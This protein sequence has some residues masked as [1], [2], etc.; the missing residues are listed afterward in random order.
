MARIYFIP[1]Q[2]RSEQLKRAFVVKGLFFHFLPQGT[3]PTQAILCAP[4]GFFIGYLIMSLQ[5]PCCRQLAGWHSLSGLSPGGPIPQS[6][7]LE[8][9]LLGWLGASL[10]AHKSYLPQQISERAGQF[11]QSLVL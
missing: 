7:R 10:P 2:L 3:F 5:Q 6:L 1:D 4:F 9:T 11:H 8:T